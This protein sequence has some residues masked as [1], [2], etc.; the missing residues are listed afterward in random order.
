[1]QKKEWVAKKLRK[2][3][4]LN[5]PPQVK[6]N[7]FTQSSRILR[8]SKKK[9]ACL[10]AERL[11]RVAALSAPLKAVWLFNFSILP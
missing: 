2:G 11:Y 9:G 6:A 10:H 5:A 1:M 3:L 4:L 8:L 7:F